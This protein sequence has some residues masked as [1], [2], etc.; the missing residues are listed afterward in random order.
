MSPLEALAWG[1]LIGAIVVYL[2]DRWILRAERR[3][4]DE[5]ERLNVRRAEDLFRQASRSGLDTMAWVRFP[6]RRGEV[7]VRMPSGRTI[8]LR[9]QHR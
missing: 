9:N 1:I 6:A 7:R 4:L 2:L 5:L 8:R 3:H